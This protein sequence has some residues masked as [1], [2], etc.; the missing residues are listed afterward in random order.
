MTP[1]SIGVILDTFL[2]K[3]GSDDIE[4]DPE[5]R[6]LFQRLKLKFDVY[7][8]HWTIVPQGETLKLLQKYLP[9]IF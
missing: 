7:T 4:N 9:E 8:A 1:K 2:E 5:L 6:E 3:Y